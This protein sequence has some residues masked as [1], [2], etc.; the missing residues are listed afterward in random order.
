MKHLA[1]VLMLAGATALAQTTK[2]EIVPEQSQAR[3]LVKEQLANLNLPNDAIGVSKGVKGT[4]SFDRSGKVLEG[5]KFTVDLSALQSD[6]S[7]RD[8]FIKRNTLNTDQYPL[9]E[10]TPKEIKGL[11]LPLPASGKV[12]VQ[13]LGDLKIRT[14]VKPVTWE[15]E[16]EFK[17]GTAVLQ[18]KTSFTFQDFGL[19][20][21]KVFVV[22]SVDEIIRLEAT[23]TLKVAS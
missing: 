2:L 10:F 23:F 6:E 14:A 20:Q 22:L 12:K 15:G 1:L 21:P 13:I 4:V 17:G 5:S 11:T 16:V 3:Y 18:A 19:T 8:G 9:A 7:R